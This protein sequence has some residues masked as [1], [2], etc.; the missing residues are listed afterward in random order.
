MTR[1]FGYGRFVP[2]LPT[3]PAGNEREGFVRGTLASTAVIGAAGAIGLVLWGRG[4][5]AVAFGMGAA[6][7]LGNFWLIAQAT[8]RLGFPGSTPGAGHLWKGAALRFLLV[9]VVL[10]LALVVFRVSLVGLVAGLLVTQVWMVCH[11]LFWMLRA[12]R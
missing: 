2:S 9:G 4:G 7:S 1:P 5:W 10:I 6:I 8:S 3:N 12:E 11:W